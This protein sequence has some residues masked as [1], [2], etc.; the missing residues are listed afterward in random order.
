M[1]AEIR[2]LDVNDMRAGLSSDKFAARAAWLRKKFCRMMN[3]AHDPATRNEQEKPKNRW[4]IHPY[5]DGCEDEA[6]PGTVP[7]H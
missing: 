3:E 4:T 7:L 2:N 5:V 6:A 1:P